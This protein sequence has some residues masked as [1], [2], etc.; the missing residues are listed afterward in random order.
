[1]THDDK[2][3]QYLKRLTAELRT[4]RRRID[5]LVAA[6]HEPIAVVGMGCRF[7]GGVGSADDL[8]RLVSVGEDAIV[9]W[10]RDRG[11]D[12]DGLYDPDP[13]RAGRFYTRG[14]GFLRDAG[15]FDAELF[16]I[17]PR[18]ALAMDPQQRQLLEVCWETL[19]TAGIRPEALRGSST[20]VFMGAYAQGYGQGMTD[21]AE[22]TEGYILT[23]TLTSVISGRIAYT[24]GLQGPAVT[25]DT[26]CSSSLVALHLA[27]QSLRRGES[28]MAL[29]GGVTLMAVPETFVGFS[30]QRALSADGRC[31]AFGAGAD[32]FGPGEGA[33]V[34]LLERLSDAQANGHPVLAV[35]RGSAVNQDGASNGLSAPNGPSQERVIRQ[36]LADAGLTADDI[37]AVEAHGTGT[38]LGDPIEAG[39][40]L[41]TYG[42]NRAPERPLWLG[43][44]KSNI[45]HPQAAAGVAG[46]IKMVMALRHGVLPRTLHAEE[47]SPHVDWESGALRLLTEPTPWNGPGPRR[48]A[49]SSFGISGTNAHLIVE[50]APAGRPGDEVQERAAAGGRLRGTVAVPWLLSGKTAGALRAQAARLLGFVSGD[51]GPDLVDIGHSLATTRARLAARAVIVADDRATFRHGLECL[52]EGRPAACLTEG[53]VAEELAGTVFV[54]PGQ[55]SQW[56]GMAAELLD[57]APV[58]AQRMR[59]CERALAPVVD[60]SLTDVIRGLPGAPPTDRVDVV[61]P[62][63]WAVMVSLAALWRSYGVTP[64]AVVGHSQ[65]EI[66]AAVV[67]GALSLEDGARVVALRSRVLTRLSGLGGM[68]SVP[69]PADRV[70]ERLAAYDGRLGIAAVNG[71]ASTV[72]SGDADALADLTSGYQNEGVRAKRVPV[73]YASHSAH[74]DAIRD[75]VTRVLRDIAPRPSDVLFYSTV[76]GEAVGTEGLDAAY[77]YR[78]LRR[79]V[80]YEDAVRSLLD[81]DFG[82]FVECSPHPVLTVG[83]QE[84]AD[85]AGRAAVVVGTLARDQGGLGRFHTA[86]AEAYVHGVA[87]DW[88]P[89]FAPLGGRRVA[90]P[91]YAFQHRRYWLEAAQAAGDVSSAGLRTAGHPLL[92]AVLPSAERDEVT[93]S[94]RLSLKAQPWLADHAVAGVVLL[95][96]TAF[97]ELALRAGDEVGCDRVRELAVQAPLVLPEEGAV[98]LQVVVGGPDEAGL[99]EVGVFS[100]PQDTGPAQPWTRHASGVLA[101]D[102]GPASFD[103]SEW[104]PPGAEP[105]AVDTVRER[106]A[107]SGY[108]YGPAFQGLTA[109]YRAGEE[110]FA[111][112]VLPAEAGAG[113]PAEDGFGIHPALLDS[114][115]HALGTDE[116]T[117]DEGQVRLPFGWKGVRLFATADSSVR[118][119]L[120]RTGTDAVAIEVADAAGRPV[121]SVEELML[122]PVALAGLTAGAGR[123]PDLPL[124][125]EWTPAPEDSPVAHRSAGA[126]LRA[127]GDSAGLE[128]T[129]GGDCR[130]HDGPAAFLDALDGGSAVPDTVLAVVGGGPP[131]G[132]E[133]AGA[134]LAAAV[135]TV[136]GRVLDLLR[137]WL[138]DKRLAHSRLVL[139]TRRAVATGPDEGVDD[140]AAAGVWG[141]VRSAQSEHPGRFVLADLDGAASA[142]ALVGAIISDQPQLAVRGGRILVPRLVRSA[143]ADGLTLPAGPAP[144]RLATTGAGAADGLALLPAPE[145]AAPLRAGQ[146]RVAVRAAGVGPADVRGARGD[147]SGPLGAEGAGVV[148]EVGPGVTGPAVGDRVMGLLPHAFGPLAVADARTVVGLPEDWSYERGASVP[149]DWVTALWALRGPAELA[150]GETVLVH[151]ADT[152]PGT[153]AV[154]LAR[155]LGAEVFAT[156]GEAGRE[157]LRAC[158]VDDARLVRSHGADVEDAVLAASEGRGVDVLLDFSGPGSPA[159]S[160]R[161]LPRGGR[162]V[163]AG[164]A[165]PAAG[166]PEAAAHPAVRH[167]SCDLADAGPERIGPMLREAVRLL[168]RGGPGAPQ[169]RIWD[170]RRAAEAFRSVGAPAQGVPATPGAPTGEAPPRP[171]KA[172][173]SIPSALDPHGTVLITGG[174]GTLGG[175]IARHLVAVHGVRHLLLASRQGARAPGADGLRDALTAAGAEVTVAAC[176]AADRDDLDR[177]LARIAPEHPLTGVVHAAGTLDD[178]LLTALTPERLEAVLRPKADAAVNLHE[179]TAGTGLALFVVFSSAAGVLGNAGQANYSAANTFLDALVQHRRSLGLPALSL[180][181]GLWQEASGLTGT[182]AGTDHARLGRAGI[183]PMPTERALRLFDSALRGPDAVAVPALIDE[184]ALRDQETAGLLPA[185]LR[186][187]GAAPP[188]RRAHAASAAPSSSALA[189]RLRGLSPDDQDVALTDLVRGH[190]AVALGHSGP[191]AVPGGRA[192]KDLGFDSLAAVDL[193]NRLGAATGVRLP[194]TVVFEHPTPRALAAY[195]REQLTPRAASGTAAVTAELDRLERVL[196][197]LAG[198]VDERDAEGIGTRLQGLL[199]RWAGRQPP[200]EGAAPSPDDLAAA[201]DEELFSALDDEFRA[202]GGEGTG[203]LAGGVE[204]R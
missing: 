124:R 41:A 46:V 87:V 199:R 20:G 144:W 3:V 97:L 88:E 127:G 121:A 51:A 158:G 111:E 44:V 4:T 166:H 33:G 153:A 56:D 141:L 110:T 115:L 201:T 172:V 75:E 15:D 203:G 34:L 29:A 183:A 77:W 179:A 5:E 76:S 82:V 160:L 109:V 140:L 186:N 13:D 202:Y 176:D 84:T 138:A 37:D 195:L 90:L 154:L 169:V 68:L 27:C 95:P 167:R 11:W 74:V 139:V 39:A 162:F 79:T 151:G 189:E 177:L 131:A 171:A 125:V 83:T 72:V 62:V 99:R 26:A 91:T 146:I 163:A 52:A 185:I 188:R 92:A 174:T 126:L 150:P 64:D 173:L 70:T 149:S 65:G 168:R 18:E 30:R 53:T 85:A 132:P 94:G 98:Q 43:S 113:A 119:R 108:D 60:W 73:D 129:L 123:A 32:G 81:D 192:F 31:R 78:N 86:L 24:Y 182:L 17:S 165:L 63:L 156:A 54:F 104:P 2:S 204:A 28:S 116:L 8:W 148:T 134:G 9:P 100:R 133:P 197:G 152:G 66:A 59:A 40:L 50:E 120:S 25:V 107:D 80:R 21:R 16:G 142:A 136:T 159:L 10:P 117:A 35:V 36:A 193:R 67:A 1:M 155:H 69:L 93:L 6:Q 187:L 112:A 161:L 45:G 157:L 180:D 7:P 38:T 194:V 181:W 61:Q 130:I 164:G 57:T 190:A 145:A 147:V 101:P 19:E 114:V 143:A 178:G 58:F 14:G 106:L 103:L 128:A 96:G 89:V 191:E 49:V 184:A 12:V 55:G 22:G 170:A 71:P 122:R 48:A 135:R 175:L 200:A 196:A 137:T 198:E 42:E 102:T 47:P 118:V 23:G 105:V